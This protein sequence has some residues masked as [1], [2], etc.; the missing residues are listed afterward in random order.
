[1]VLLLNF[2]HPLTDDQVRQVTELIGAPPTV[3]TVPTQ[4]DR[5]Q[6]LGAT[7]LALAAATGLTGHDWQTRPL[8][9][10]LPGLA[11]VAAALLA[12]IHG[13]CGYFPPVL[14]I[15]PVAGSLPPRYEVAEIVN[16][17][18]LRDQARTRRYTNTVA[19]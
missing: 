17:Q 8:I 18:G 9:V 10:N 12:E 1:M 5:T 11:P 2:A 19:P 16:L 13:R 15:R 4:V 3:Q 7:A 14:N 6:P